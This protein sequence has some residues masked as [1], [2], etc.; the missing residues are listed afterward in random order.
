MHNMVA[1]DRH[2]GALV[3]SAP[4]KRDSFAYSTPILINLPEKKVLVGTS[5]NH[6]HV[7]DRQNG[8]LH[9][10]YRLEDIKYGYEHCNS[11]IYQDGYIYFVASEEHGQG[12]V[13]L[14]E[15]PLVSGMLF[16]DTFDMTGP[17]EIM[18]Y[19]GAGRDVVAEVVKNP[20][21]VEAVA[22]RVEKI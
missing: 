1:L 2:T 13:K 15:G 21:G 22:F 19:Y 5:R 11:V 6:I 17:A 8:T 18:K 14:Q 16:D 10:S 3:W 4:L 20:E 7:V 9:S 12:T